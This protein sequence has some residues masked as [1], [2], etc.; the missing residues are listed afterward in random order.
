MSRPLRVGVSTCPNDTFAFHALFERELRVPGLELEFELGDVQ[1][2]NERLLSG[3][4]DV[5]K[6]S[7]STALAAP[8][9]LVVLPSG[10]ALGFGVGPVLLAAKPLEL[11]SL[12]ANARVLTPGAGTTAELLYRML[13][14]GLGRIERRV[15]SEIM[16]AL[17]A[18]Q[19]ELGVCIHE[20]RFT[21][22]E[23]GLHLI[24]DLGASYESR[25]Q[26][27]L[28][29]GGILARRSLGDAALRQLSRAIGASIDRA[30]ANPDATLPTMRRHAAESDDAAIWGH[31][32]LYVNE[33]TRSLGP[34]GREAL[35][36]FARV[37]REAGLAPPGAELQVL[38]D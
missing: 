23:R 8:D 18:G 19:A 16:P 3:E 25:T 28:P 26:S 36:A 29:L 34:V 5:S 2:L 38:D 32:E 24:E 35:A 31:V 30:R 15:F 20:G 6:A 33:W 21:W 1:E 22:R 11:E 7:F 37:A 14:P 27:P 9:E 12:A 17:A 4:L 10:C 13:Y